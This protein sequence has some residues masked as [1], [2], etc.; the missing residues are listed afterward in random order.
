[1]QPFKKYAYYVGIDPGINNGFALYDTTKKQ[2]VKLQT[3]SFWKLIALL[4]DMEEIKLDY[5]VV[6]EDT[7]LNSFIYG[8]HNGKRGA[9]RDRVAQNVGSNKRDAAL[10]IEWLEMKGRE[11]KPVKPTSKSLT[12]IDEVTFKN[13]TKWEGKSSQHS[14]DAAFLVY[15]RQ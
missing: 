10:I 7:N 14:R 15:N 2:L 12:K 11:V 9:V 1:M 6:I 5:C 3:L 13:Y 8:K 4:T